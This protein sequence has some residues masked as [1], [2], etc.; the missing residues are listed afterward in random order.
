MYG[1]DG[2][3]ELTEEILDHLD[4]YRGRAGPDRQR[5]RRPAPARHLRRADG[6][7]LPLQQVR[8]ADLLRLLA[9]SVRD[10]RLG[11]RELGS[12]DEGIWETRGGRQHFVYSKF[13]CWVAVERAPAS[14]TA[15]AAGRSRRLDADARRHLPPDHDEGLGRGA[16]AFVQHYGS[17][18][19]DASNLLMPLVNSSPPP[20]RAGSRRST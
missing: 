19:L 2:S 7:R 20:I 3:P 15:L 11:L 8:N 1:I 6:L 16:Q 12:P 4:G 13:M 9:G 17:D 18:A 14:P 5:R 10:R